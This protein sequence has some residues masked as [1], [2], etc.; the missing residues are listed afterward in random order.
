MFCCR[1]S[2]TLKAFHN[3]VERTSEQIGYPTCNHTPGVLAVLQKKFQGRKMM[4][5]LLLCLFLSRCRYGTAAAIG[6]A[7]S[8]VGEPCVSNAGNRDGDI[9]IAHGRQ[10]R[11]VQQ[12]DVRCNSAK[13]CVDTTNKVEISTG[14][15]MPLIS[16][17][18]WFDEVFFFELLVELIID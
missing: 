8:I 15:W 17:G 16:L 11:R 18:T 6:H 4:R 1:N 14:I 10:L 9:V 12:V 7:C 3:F 13:V 5:Y 2:W